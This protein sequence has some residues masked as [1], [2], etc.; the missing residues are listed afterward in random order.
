M[1]VILY[2]LNLTFRTQVISQRFSLE[3]DR[4]L[5]DITLYGK[6]IDDDDLEIIRRKLSNR[7]LD[8]ADLVVR[9]LYQEDFIAATAQEFLRMSE[10]LKIGIIEDL[11]KKN[12]YIIVSKDVQ[13]KF[14]ENQVIKPQQKRYP[15]GDIRKELMIQYPDMRSFAIGDMINDSQDTICHAFVSFDRGISKSEKTK[16]SAWLKARSKVD[17]IAVVLQ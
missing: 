8:N 3:D 14:L 6:K 13:I 10:D 15:V 17:S 5:I 12:E 7:N 2:L 11:Y 4:G 1:P 9:Q 16:I